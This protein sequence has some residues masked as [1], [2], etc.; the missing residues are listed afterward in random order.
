M[1]KAIYSQTMKKISVVPVILCGGEG[2]RLWPVSRRDFPKQFVPLLG[3]LSCFQQAA[4]RLSKMDGALAP[5]IV[6]G[7]A[8]EMLVRRQ[9]EELSLDATIILEPEGRDSGPAA[10]AAA[11][12]LA[13]ASPDCV[14]IMQPADH[15]IPDIGEFHKAA[16]LAAVAADAGA[17]VTFG[18]A[19]TAPEISYGYIAPGDALANARGVSAVSRF[20]EKPSREKAAEYLAEGYVWNS[21]IFAFKPQV[22]MAEMRA[23][24]PVIAEQVERAIA[25]AAR[26]GNVIRLDADAFSRA[27]KKSLDYAVMERTKLAA[28][29]PAK[30]AWS[31][32]G[33]WNAIHSESEKDARGN[34][35][36]G[37]SV[38]LIDSDNCLVRAPRIPVSVIGLENVGVIAEADGVIVCNLDASASVKNAVDALRAKGRAEAF[39][40]GVTGMGHFTNLKTASAEL[41]RWLRSSALP[42]WW[43]AG[44]DHERSGFFELLDS[45]GCAVPASRRLR[46]QARQIYV[47][48]QAG[49][50]DWNGPWKTAVRSGLDFLRAKYRLAD[51][52]YRTLVTDDGTPA[53]DTVFLYDQTFVL[54]A[55]AS[56]AERGPEISAAKNAW[57]KPRICGSCYR[58]NLPAPADGLPSRQC[59]VRCSSRILTCICWKRLWRG[60][61]WMSI[62]IGIGLRIRSRSF[63]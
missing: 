56:T 49:L 48:A 19:P 16:G 6:T 22:L 53:D 46:V 33:A 26:D 34:A 27:P 43:S 40:G 17:I 13:N 20:A 59:M 45:D 7:A 50:S 24:E 4:L 15:Y 39:R 41:S 47:F 11:M 55:L 31:D 58:K 1:T 5:V 25:N 3:N 18:I 30:F 37:D 36:F 44:A 28:V 61:N 2:S 14:A 21:G 63:V 60:A 9:L 52:F 42:L 54:L 8:H 57:Q 10:L 35:V 12:F 32:L 62:R 23:F 38:V 51:G 29:V